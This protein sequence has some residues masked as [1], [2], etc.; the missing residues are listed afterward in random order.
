MEDIKR[1]FY[2]IEIICE[3]DNKDKLTLN[4]LMAQSKE[5]VSIDITPID[6]ESDQFKWVKAVNSLNEL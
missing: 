3:W 2:K 5:P 6:I 4:K 1:Q